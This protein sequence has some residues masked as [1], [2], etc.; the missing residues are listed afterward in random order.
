MLSFAPAD[1]SKILNDNADLVRVM[2]GL[3]EFSAS[4]DTEKPKT[5]AA[6]IVDQIQ[7]FNS[8]NSLWMR[9]TG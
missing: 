3:N 9:I 8:G 2:A 1:V 7:V 5:A 6:A 4:A